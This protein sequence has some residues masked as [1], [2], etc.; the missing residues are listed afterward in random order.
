VSIIVPNIRAA[1]KG[2]IN[3]EL[4]DDVVPKTAENFATICKGG[5]KGEHYKGTIFHRVIPNFML[6]G[7]DFTRHNVWSR[8][9][10]FKFTSLTLVG[11]WRS[12]HLWREVPRRELQAQA[13]P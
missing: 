11:H 12:L 5:P 8:A 7:G 1:Q 4:Y 13:R 9:F 6:Q 2:R 10:L 3:F